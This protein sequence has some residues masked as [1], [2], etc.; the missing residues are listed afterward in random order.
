M[1]MDRVRG[2][3]ENQINWLEEKG[4]EKEEEDE[5]WIIKNQDNSLKCRLLLSPKIW[6]QELK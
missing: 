1:E 5:K 2:F 3:L 4:K 6:F